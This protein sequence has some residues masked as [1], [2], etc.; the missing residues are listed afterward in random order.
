M[1]ALLGPLQLPYAVVL[2]AK[3][4]AYALGWL[5][6]RRLAWPVVSVG[7]LSVGGAGK[8][9]VVL[10]LAE[11]L[12]SEG[13]HVD[14][15]SRGYGRRSTIPVERV[16][17][18]HDAARF[19]DEPLLLARTAGVPVYVG[20]SR[21]AAGCLA[22]QEARADSSRSGVHLLDDGF[23]HRK[24]A[25]T[26]DIVVLHPSDGAARLL[27]AGRLREPLR[28]L[29]RADLLLLREGDTET[30]AALERFGILTPRMRLRR[31]LTVPSLAGPAFAFCGIAHPEEFFRQLGTAGVTLSGTLAFRDHHR[32]TPRDL[33][34]II[35]RARGSAALLTTDKDLV[36]LSAEARTRLSACA[37]LLS[38]GLR[39]RFAD[40]EGLAALLRARLARHVPSDGERSV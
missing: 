21:Y 32:F 24:L 36:R 25:R 29:R 33:E 16:Q 9:P 31:E 8:T 23:Q 4:A 18:A 19:G 22:E 2:G 13:M 40:A 14:I 11:M 6:P 35:A 26:L 30:E 37:P 3:N 27:P 10:A 20:A 5:R 1:S 34:A 12:Q 7:N 38:A 15:L 39:V 28:A 17:T